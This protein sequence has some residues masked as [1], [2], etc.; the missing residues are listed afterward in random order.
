MDGVFL[1]GSTC[2]DGESITIRGPQS[3]YVK[4]KEFFTVLGGAVVL[5]VLFKVSDV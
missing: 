3:Q 1:D 2:I 4:A 5:V